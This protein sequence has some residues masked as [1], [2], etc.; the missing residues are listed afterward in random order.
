MLLWSS[1]QLPT[2][3]KETLRREEVMT[4]KRHA[5]S[6]RRTWKDKMLYAVV[7]FVSAL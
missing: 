1:Q 3:T 5:K 7:S 6:I 2:S 4:L